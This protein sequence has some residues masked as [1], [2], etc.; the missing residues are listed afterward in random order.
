MIINSVIRTSICGQSVDMAADDLTQ[1]EGL[2]KLSKA[3]YKCKYSF[4]LCKPE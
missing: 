4:S 1:L 3:I 2:N